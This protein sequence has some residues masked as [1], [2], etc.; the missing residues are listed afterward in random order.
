MDKRQWEALVER[1]AEERRARHGREAK[2]QAGP[3]PPGWD[4]GEQ[5]E[6][7]VRMGMLKRMPEKRDG[8]YQYAPTE[9]FLEHVE[10][11]EAELREMVEQEMVQELI[12]RGG[13]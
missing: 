3:P 8:H 5:L 13:T 4:A 1:R 9:E 11:W 12:E 2:Q 10:E 7:L 6:E